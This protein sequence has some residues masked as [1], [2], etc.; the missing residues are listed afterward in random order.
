MSYFEIYLQNLEL[1]LSKLKIENA[2]LSDRVRRLER[3]LDE[4]EKAT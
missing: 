2:T 1:E 4:A 3:P